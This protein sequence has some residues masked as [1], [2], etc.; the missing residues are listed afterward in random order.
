MRAAPFGVFA[1]GRPAEAARLAAIDGSMS[2]GGEGVYGGRAVA[3]GR[4]D[5]AVVTAAQRTL[6]LARRR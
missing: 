2:H 4:F 5:A 3:D 1:A 6:S